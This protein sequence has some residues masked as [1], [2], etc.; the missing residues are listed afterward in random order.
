MKVQYYTMTDQDREYI[1]G[2]IQ[3]LLDDI[4][5]VLDKI[6]ADKNRFRQTKENHDE[7]ILNYKE[8]RTKR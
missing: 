7:I 1:I 6:H 5:R 2:E 8:T 4:P 3:N